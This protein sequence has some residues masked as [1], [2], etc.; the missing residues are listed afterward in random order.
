MLDHEVVLRV[1][2]LSLLCHLKIDLG[3]ESDVRSILGEWEQN[4]FLCGC[5]GNGQE[6]SVLSG[7]SERPAGNEP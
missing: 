2:I 6:F 3:V 4:P 7:P 5:P 1:L